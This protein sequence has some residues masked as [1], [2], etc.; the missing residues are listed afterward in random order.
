[1]RLPRRST[2]IRRTTSPFRTKIANHKLSPLSQPASGEDAATK[3]ASGRAWIDPISVSPPLTRQRQEDQDQ[4]GTGHRNDRRDQPHTRSA[5]VMQP[6]RRSGETTPDGDQVQQDDAPSQKG[7]QSDLSNTPR[8][9]SRHPRPRETRHPTRSAPPASRAPSP[10]F[11][12]R[13]TALVVE[14]AFLRRLFNHSYRLPHR[15]EHLRLTVNKQ[16][17]TTL[18]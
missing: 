10:P 7:L 4:D 12:P 3:A 16:S 11:P 8:R 14:Q 5:D 15:S 6:P 2:L 1:M 13:R 9:R 17:G 18:E